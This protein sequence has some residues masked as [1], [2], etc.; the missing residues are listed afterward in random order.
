[1]NIAFGYIFCVN[2][3][4][5]HPS[6]IERECIQCLICLIIKNRI[7]P[8]WLK[9]FVICCSIVIV[10]GF[11]LSSLALSILFST[12]YVSYVMSVMPSSVFKYKQKN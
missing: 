2:T 6:G 3:K 7:G 10:M 11:L 1:M 9:A 4:R 8:V 12:G 5:Q